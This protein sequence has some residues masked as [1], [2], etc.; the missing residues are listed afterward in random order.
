MALILAMADASCAGMVDLVSFGMVNAAI[1]RM[2]VTTI[3]SSMSVNPRCRL[4]LRIWDLFFVSSKVLPMPWLSAELA[5]M[6][7]YMDKRETA[8]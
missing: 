2:M 6:E 5:I 4:R 7:G 8:A 3:N 1:I